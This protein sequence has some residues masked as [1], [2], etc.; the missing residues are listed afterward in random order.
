MG[1]V[2][3]GTAVAGTRIG[4]TPQASAS[5]EPPVA[6]AARR[7]NPLRDTL[8]LSYSS[9]ERLPSSERRS[10]I[11]NSSIWWPEDPKIDSCRSR[12]SFNIYAAPAGTDSISTDRSDIGLMVPVEKPLW[13]TLIFDFQLGAAR[14]VRTGRGTLMHLASRMSEISSSLNPGS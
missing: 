11:F 10:F 8:P 5:T 9:V 3:G 4:S 7:K 14:V 13:E 2:V 1:A 12:K 6:T